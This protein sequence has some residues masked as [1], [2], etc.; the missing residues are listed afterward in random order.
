[1]KEAPVHTSCARP[2]DSRPAPGWREVV[3]FLLPAACL[4]CEDRLPLEVEGELVCATCLSR[5]REAPWPRCPRCHFPSGTGRAAAACAACR[6]W[7]SALQTARSVVIL[8][9]VAERLVHALKY[10]GWKELAPL[11]AERMGALPLPERAAA[12]DVLVVPMPTTRKRRRQRGYNQAG[13]ISEAYALRTGRPVLEALER[14]GGGGSQV[15]LHPAQR[16]TNVRRAFS[17]APALAAELQGRHV[18][19]VDDVLTTGATASE[20][21]L[22]LER[23]GADGVSLITFARALPDRRRPEGRPR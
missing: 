7:P 1:V 18:I 23:A 2:P 6:D 16:R 19:L 22:T 17:V 11:L 3:D 20:A 15:A 10:Q 13:R 14:T 4:A 8:E 5:L 9:D 12:A 21:A